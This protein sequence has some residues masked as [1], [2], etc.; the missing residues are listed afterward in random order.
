MRRPKG[1]I[2]GSER[3]Q[4]FGAGVVDDMAQPQGGERNCATVGDLARDDD[5]KLGERP[6]RRKRIGLHRLNRE[7]KG[8]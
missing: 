8:D 3:Q 1:Q 6:G 5:E 2:G 4:D 7:A